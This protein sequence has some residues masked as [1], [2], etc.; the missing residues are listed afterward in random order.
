MNTDLS[1]KHAIVGGSTQGIGKATA[2]ELAALGASVTLIAR[3]EEKLQAISREL[4]VPKQQQHAYICADFT[5]PEVLKSKLDSQLDK[6]PP[7]NILVNNTGGPPGGTA[8]EAEIDEYDQAFKMHLICNQILLQKVLPGMQKS[9][10][11]RV[12]NIIST[13]VKEPI[14][15]LGVSNTIRGAVANWAKTLSKELGPYG[16]TVNNVLPGATNTG[17]IASL[18]AKKAEEGNKTKKEVEENMK[19]AIPL[20]RFAEPSELAYAVAFLAS[21]SGAY[22]SGVNLPVDGGKLNTH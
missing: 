14:I 15:G 20:Q 1:G 16:I 9:G 10:Y 13:S 3:D 7:V 18:I 8:H 6:L 5:Q 11:G 19:A 2:E 4:P 12:I 22:I 17:R 21:P